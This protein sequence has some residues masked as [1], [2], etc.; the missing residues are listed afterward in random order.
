MIQYKS[1]SNYSLNQQPKFTYSTTLTAG[2]K[3]KLLKRKPIYRL[4]DDDND[5]DYIEV[6]GGSDTVPY[7]DDE[8]NQYEI[9][10]DDLIEYDGDDGEIQYTSS[11]KRIPIKHLKRWANVKSLIQ[12]TIRQQYKAKGY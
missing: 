8:G 4:D 2:N 7:T 6:P 3:S 1:V 5:D 12:N 10:L 9:P 11:Q